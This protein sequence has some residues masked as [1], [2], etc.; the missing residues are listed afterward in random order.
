MISRHLKDVIKTAYQQ[1][2]CSSNKVWLVLAFYSGRDY[3][4]HVF[5]TKEKAQRYLN[6]LIPDER[7][8][9]ESEHMRCAIEGDNPNTRDECLEHGYCEIWHDPD[10]NEIT[11]YE[12]SEVDVDD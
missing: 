8:V 11:Y 1:K 6:R 7:T 4:Y 5:S 2:Y 12:M 9:R 10:G 3:D